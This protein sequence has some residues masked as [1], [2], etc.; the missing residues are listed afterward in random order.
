MDYIYGDGLDPKFKS[1]VKGNKIL[2][3]QE[4]L[5]NKWR[6]EAQSLSSK[7]RVNEIVR[8][9]KIEYESK[10]NEK[11]GNEMMYKPSPPKSKCP[12]KQLIRNGVWMGLPSKEVETD[13]TELVEEMKTK[14]QLI[15]ELKSELSNLNIRYN[16][17]KQENDMDKDEFDLYF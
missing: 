17:L 10:V 14:D 15:A 9:K 7:D 3:Y 13:V 8:L 16:T 2:G 1:G 11:A 4:M 12:P 6:L 5:E